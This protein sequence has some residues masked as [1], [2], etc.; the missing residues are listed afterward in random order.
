MLIKASVKSPTYLPGHLTSFYLKFQ[1]PESKTRA[2][3]GS[4][5][6]G[7]QRGRVHD[8]HRLHLRHVR[9][10][11]SAG[12]LHVIA[13]G[14]INRQERAGHRYQGPHAARIDRCKIL[15]FLQR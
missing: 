12:I 11:Q 8:R 10:R 4:R 2:S 1:R 3:R 9:V 14:G 15:F 7:L 6:R 5:D 13:K